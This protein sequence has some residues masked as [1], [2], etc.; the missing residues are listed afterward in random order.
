MA[1]PKRFTIE[2]T[3]K[4]KA[5]VIIG[6]GPSFTLKQ[7]RMIARARFEPA[8]KF[9]VIAVNDAFYAASWAD[10]LHACDATW[11]RAHIHAAQ[12]FPGIKTTLDETVPEPWVT[13]YLENSGS[14]GFDPDPSK[15]RTGANS[16][17]QAM[18]IAIH[19]GASK[20]ILVGVDM[21]EGPKGEK[22]WFGDHDGSA[23]VARVGYASVMIPKFA[24]L[25]PT[26][27]LRGVSVV[28][29]TPGSALTTFP[30]VDLE[31]A[32]REV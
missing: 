6:G 5:V 2:P 7:N 13:G 22:H 15:C 17:Y 9:R 11:W 16:V 28:N 18:C 21:K 29:A 3:F 24:T 30:I 32:L 10:L 26:L 23:G 20:I 8:S 14:D 19:A 4:D 25:V 27:T 1:L 12:W 31:S